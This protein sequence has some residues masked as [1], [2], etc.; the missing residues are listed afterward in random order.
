MADKGE[1]EL[2]R[3]SV[4][5][6]LLEQTAEE[7]QSRINMVNA[8]ITD[9]NYASMTLEGIEKEKENSELFVPIGSNS[10]IKAKLENPDK[11]IVGMGAGVS[12]EKTLPE[13]KE[14]IKKRVENLDKTRT[15]LQQQ[16]AQ[17]TDR[18]SGDR[19]K[20]ENMVAELRGEKTS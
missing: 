16:L 17:I 6:R 4:E 5:L 8:I 12:I 3:L 14:I 1:E 2:R 15:S 19:E 9:L 7:M 18:I 20:F 11:I 13:A 10:Y